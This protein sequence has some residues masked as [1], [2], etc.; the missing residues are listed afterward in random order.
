MRIGE[1]YQHMII[2]VSPISQ[3]SSD[4]SRR[5]YYEQRPPNKSDEQKNDCSE[6]HI[7]YLA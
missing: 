2:P 4:T 5:Q 6:S 1:K 3:V 7:D